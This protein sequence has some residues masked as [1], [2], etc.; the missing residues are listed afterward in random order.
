MTDPSKISDMVSSF[1]PYLTVDES[2]DA[3]TLV[4]YGMS[5]N[6]MRPSNITS[7]TIPNAGTGTTAGGASVV[8]PD[9]NELAEMRKSM[10][11]GSMADYV[12]GLEKRQE[13]Q[14][15]GA[16]DES[17]EQV[18]TQPGE[19]APWWY[20][21]SFLLPIPIP[22]NLPRLNAAGKGSLP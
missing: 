19:E 17:G 20:T 6:K 8:W 11:E 4:S 3:E 15:E 12:E 7:F 18:T 10:R 13:E 22:R 21:G 1:T 5:M 9:E 2:L 14:A 16:T